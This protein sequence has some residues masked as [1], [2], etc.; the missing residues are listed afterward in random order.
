M[1]MGVKS[2]SRIRMILWVFLLVGIALTVV[3]RGEIGTLLMNEL[4][5]DTESQLQ[6]LLR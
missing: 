3:Y 2:T 5:S 6:Q 1:S 4:A